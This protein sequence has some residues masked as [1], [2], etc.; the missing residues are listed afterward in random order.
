MKRLF[1]LFTCT[2]LLLACGGGDDAG[3]GGTPTGGSEYLNVSNVDIPGGNTTATLNIQASQNC[4]WVISWNDSWIRSV[5]PTKGRGSQNVT[6]TVTVNPSS[7]AER[8]AILTVKNTSGSITRNV[9]VTQSPNAE[10]LELSTLSISF[11][12]AASSQDVTVTSNTHW[13]ITGMASWLTLSKTSGDD[14]GV[15][16]ITVDEN[17]EEA[18]RSAV[19]TFTGASGAVKQIA[20]IQSGRSSNFNV[21]PTSI[22]ADALASQVT[23]TI[24]GEARWTTKSN[25][26]WAV[27]SDVSGQGQKEVKVSLS[28]NISESA[29]TAEI[30]VNSATKSEKVVITQAGASKPVLTEIKQSDITHVTQNAATI[31]IGYSSQYPVTEY[32]ICYSS[33]NS[34]PTVSDSH[35]S[36]AGSLLQGTKTFSL[37]SLS[38]GTTYYVRAYATSA[39]GTQYSNAISFTT[40]S[41][42]P[43]GGDNVTPGI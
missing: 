10:T 31:A 41:D 27:L 17:T 8:T 5:S 9:T 30:T 25:Q 21:S 29:R 6:I 1:S 15:V 37:T 2:L 39:V 40:I 24:V 19:L 26:S 12:N 4:E 16:K 11:T 22:S 33:S 14:N 20:I 35:L 32:G 7:S 38:A 28:D 18:E 13:T 34:N 42:V 3:G 43:G 23:F 36:E